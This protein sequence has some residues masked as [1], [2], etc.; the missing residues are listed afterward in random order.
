[1]RTNGVLCAAMYGDFTPSA[2]RTECSVVRLNAP[3]R[4]KA[5]TT[6]RP[7]RRCR[8]PEIAAHAAE[9]AYRERVQADDAPAPG[10]RRSPIHTVPVPYVLP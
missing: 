2:L 4:P 7:A 1:M 9:G 5:A 3:L 6:T 8:A 10:K